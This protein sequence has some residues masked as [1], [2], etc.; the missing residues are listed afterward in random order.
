MYQLPLSDGL[1]ELNR[2]E[3]KENL[4]DHRLKITRF[5]M[6]EINV[7]KHTKELEILDKWDKSKYSHQKCITHTGVQKMHMMITIFHYKKFVIIHTLY[8]EYRK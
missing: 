8:N 3:S 7:F 1:A 4:H 5:L 6:A 2:L